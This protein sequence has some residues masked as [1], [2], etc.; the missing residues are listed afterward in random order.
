MTISLDA[1][2]FIYTLN[3]DP[4]YG[5]DA[6]A[7]LQSI[8]KGETAGVASELV[9]LE[10]LS[11]KSQTGDL[12]KARQLLEVSSVK[13]V[14]ATKDILLLGAELRR[15]Y[16]VKTPDSIHL[17]T[18]LSTGVDYF[19]TNDQK[20]NKLSIDNLKVIKLSDVRKIIQ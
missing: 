13:Y 2:V 3:A 15:R 8:E 4:V 9:F 20:L 11:G 16:S 7:T 14:A 10:V 5:L 18:A 12:K 6:L 19:I 1:N 17:A